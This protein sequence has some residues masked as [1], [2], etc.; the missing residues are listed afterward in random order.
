M[1]EYRSKT[2][3]LV[4]DCLIDEAY[5]MGIQRSDCSDGGHL[6]SQ[7]QTLERLLPYLF[8]LLGNVLVRSYHLRFFSCFGYSSA[9]PCVFVLWLSCIF[10]FSTTLTDSMACR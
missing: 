2:S 10:T 1:I 5:I 4:T 7:K 8:W 6:M 3:R 9:Y